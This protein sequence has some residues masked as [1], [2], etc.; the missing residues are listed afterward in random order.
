[1]EGREVEVNPT[2]SGTSKGELKRERRDLKDM[3]RH[4]KLR[5]LLEIPPHRPAG[6]DVYHDHGL[7]ET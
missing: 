2:E 3:K 6:S 4:Q 1:M 7:L 5:T